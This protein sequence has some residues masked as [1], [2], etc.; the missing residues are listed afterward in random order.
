MSNL[1]LCVR[2]GL[3]PCPGLVQTAASLSDPIMPTVLLI[4]GLAALALALYLLASIARDVGVA[5]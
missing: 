2:W 5:R 4:A 3:P 1:S